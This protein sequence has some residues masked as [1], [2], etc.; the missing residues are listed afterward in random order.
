[1]TCDFSKKELEIIYSSLFVTKFTDKEKNIIASLLR[2]KIEDYLRD[3][4]GQEI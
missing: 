1:M 3:C 4:H 2:G